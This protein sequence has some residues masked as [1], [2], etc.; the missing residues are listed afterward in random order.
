MSTCSWKQTCTRRWIRTHSHTQ[1]HVVIIVFIISQ[2]ETTYADSY[3]TLVGWWNTAYRHQL[4]MYS[5]SI[6][7]LVNNGKVL[8][9]MRA[10]E[11]E[12]VHTGYD[13]DAE[14]TPRAEGVPL[15]IQY[16][17]RCR[18][19]VWVIDWV[20]EVFAPQFFTLVIYIC[21]AMNHLINVC[22]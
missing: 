16:I 4:L 14:C 18:N 2:R 15:V 5:V 6:W 8:Y 13:S 21:L 10:V 22:R 11:M 20:P 1:T 7:S 9:G 12:M 17:S 19:V 3:K